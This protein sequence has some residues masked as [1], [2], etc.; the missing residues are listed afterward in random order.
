MRVYTCKSLNELKINGMS[1]R[2]DNYQPY[3]IAR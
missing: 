2:S 3:I 1:T